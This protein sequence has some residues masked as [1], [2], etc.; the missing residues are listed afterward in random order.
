MKLQEKA[1]EPEVVADVQ[2]W[3]E[4]VPPE[5]VIVAMWVFMENPEPLTLTETPAGPCE[6]DKLML[7]VVTTKMEEAVM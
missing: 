4:I 3:V 2:V 7:G 1:P 6:G 5:K